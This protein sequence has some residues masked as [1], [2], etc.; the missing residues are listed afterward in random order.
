VLEAW[1]TTGPGYVLYYPSRRH[2]P[3]GLR[4]LIDLIRELQPL[5]R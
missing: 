2:V 5:G 1:S 3:T 4:A